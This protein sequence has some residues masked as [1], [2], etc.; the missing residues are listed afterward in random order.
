MQAEVLLVVANQARLEA[1]LDGTTLPL[2]LVCRALAAQ[3]PRRIRCGRHPK[4]LYDWF[5]TVPEPAHILILEL[6]HQPHTLVLSTA[7]AQ[8]RRLV[9]LRC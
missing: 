5:C 2:A 6:P 7:G 9:G 1:W 8:K 4:A 3:C